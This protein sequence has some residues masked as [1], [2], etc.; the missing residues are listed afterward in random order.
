MSWSN[1][2]TIDAPAALVWRLTTEVEDWPGLT[3]TVT[4]LKLLDPGPLRVGSRARIK[5]PG[6]PSATWTVSRLEPNRSFSWQTSRPGLTLTGTHHVTPD[7]A[8]CRNSLLVEA[9]GV[10]ARP[11]R[12]LLG[13]AVRRS[14]RL[15]NAGFKDRAEQ[16]AAGAS[17]PPEGAPT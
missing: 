17:R 6:Q 13:P 4:S 9:T 8:G 10:L 14:L 2:T 3:P 1:T 12:L 7:E 15:E 16:Q 5:Q 11:F